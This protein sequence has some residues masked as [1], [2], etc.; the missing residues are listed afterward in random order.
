M[1][2]ITLVINS[3]H[4]LCITSVYLVSESL[5][6]SYQALRQRAFGPPTVRVDQT[7]NRVAVIKQD[8]LVNHAYER[9]T[10]ARH[11]L[12]ETLTPDRHR[13]RG[14]HT[15][16]SSYCAS[17]AHQ[18]WRPFIASWRQT[19]RQADFLRMQSR[20]NLTE[21]WSLVF[22]FHVLDKS[23]FSPPSA[24]HN[25]LKPEW[26]FQ[27]GANFDCVSFEVKRKKNKKT[28]CALASRDFS[29]PFRF[30]ISFLTQSA[31]AFQESRAHFPARNVKG[32]PRSQRKKCGLLEFFSSF[33]FL[34]TFGGGGGALDVAHVLRCVCAG[35]EG[36]PRKDSGTQTDKITHRHLQR[37]SDRKSVV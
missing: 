12:S 2:K 9:E 35:A 1:W 34:E 37:V 6:F 3:V 28:M 21:G 10:W 27:A 5:I 23:F 20:V 22:C 13:A 14:S 17:V 16:C 18:L 11:R 8:E 19:V 32:I 29:L 7:V 26:Y 33:F 31:P 15:V 24:N 25:R 30:R 36:M 4:V